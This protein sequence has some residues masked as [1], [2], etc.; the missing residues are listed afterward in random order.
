MTVACTNLG[1]AA[2]M[3][4]FVININRFIIFDSMFR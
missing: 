2:R 4:H 3:D 1:G